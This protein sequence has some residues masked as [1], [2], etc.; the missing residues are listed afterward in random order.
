MEYVFLIFG[1][2]IALNFGLMTGLS[3]PSDATWD[4]ETKVEIETLVN[5]PASEKGAG[6]AAPTSALSH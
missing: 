2:L 4:D 3:D 1:T 6:F 5:E